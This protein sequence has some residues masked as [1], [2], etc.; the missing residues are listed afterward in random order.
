MTALIFVFLAGCAL[1]LT[2]GSPLI[3][4]MQTRR[5]RQHAYEDAPASHQVKTGTPTMG[6][7]LFL[8]PAIVLMVFVH[9][10]VVRDL[11][12]FTLACGVLGFVDDYLAVVHGQ[13]VGLRARTKFLA[14]AFLGI[15]FLRALS[16]GYNLYPHDVVLNLPLK[17]LVVPHWTWLLLGLAVIVATTHA[18]NLTDGLDGLAASTILPPFLVLTIVAVQ[19]HMPALAF[20]VAGIAGACFGFLFYNRHPARLFMGDTGSLALGA[21]LAGTAIVTGEHLLLLLIGGIF[22]V[23][24]LSVILQVASFKMTRRRIFRMSPLHHHFELAGWPETKVTQRF[25]LSSALL[26]ALGLAIVR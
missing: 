19:S 15:L 5:L 12:W 4:V 17:V 22:A 9:D 7:V 23:E 2:L 13:N 16:E 25:W 26:C 24:T 18:V 11:L 8:L 6:G 10:A 1:A 20:V 21:L 3:T 14:T